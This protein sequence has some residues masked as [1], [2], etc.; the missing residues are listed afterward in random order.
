LI[1]G[2]SGGA[3]TNQNGLAFERETS[4]VKQ[5]EE[6]GY[7]V[8]AGEYKFEHQIF[9][10]DGTLLLMLR[11]QSATKAWLM[12]NYGVDMGGNLSAPMRPDITLFSAETNVIT[13]IEQKFQS[14]AGSVDEKLQT[15]DFKKKQYEK[16]FKPLGIQ[17]RFIYVLSE[18][19][20]K[21]RYDD[22]KDYIIS[23]GALW[24]ISV[25]P[26]SVILAP[27]EGY[28]PLMLDTP[29]SS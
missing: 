17:V 24:F 22:V 29:G 27:R 10:H 21:S 7:C 4:P 1:L 5:F 2:G 23:V 8:L 25:I 3:K 15:V 6:N 28:P 12:R 26:I 13:I 9:D 11:T 16:I 20:T 18:W 14:V 19:F